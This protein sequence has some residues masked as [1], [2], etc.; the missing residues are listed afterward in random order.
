MPVDIAR[1]GRN[2][3][4]TRG[5]HSRTD[6]TASEV[7]RKFQAAEPMEPEVIHFR[8][9]RRSVPGLVAKLLASFAGNSFLF[10]VTE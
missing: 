3:V 7:C 6:V 2:R 4:S 5:C 8:R 10:V 1:R 9:L